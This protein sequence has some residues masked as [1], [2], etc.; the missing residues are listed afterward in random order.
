[1]IHFLQRETSMAQQTRLPPVTLHLGAHR[2]GGSTLQRMLAINA[3]ILKQRGVAVWGPDRTRDGLLAG[4]LGD[5][6]SAS[7]RR[8]IL[9]HRS[10]G[11]VAMLRGSMAGAGIGRLVMS[12]ANAL[13]GL[14]ENLLLG[15]LYPSA[16]PRLLRLASA[17]PEID[18]VVLSIRSPDVWWASV[19]SLLMTR[20]FAPPDTVTIEAI[21]RA[22]RGWRQV[23]ADVAQALPKARL[24]VWTH[25]TMASRPA[26]AFTDLTDM[27]PHLAQVPQLAASPALAVLRARLHDEGCVAV[28]PEVDGQYAPFDADMRAALRETYDA[29]LGWLRDGAGGRIDAPT[30]A[31]TGGFFRDRR[32]GYGQRRRQDQMGATG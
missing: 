18:R 1:M 13:G 2:T 32:P 25:E 15:R 31:P 11:R 4:V 6:G 14:R 19:F 7:P 5:P 28:L 9:A 29:D 8:D 27:Q 20:G 30:C 10:T 21:V 26:A 16:G 22:R 24:T 23:I 3:D 17:M 12:D